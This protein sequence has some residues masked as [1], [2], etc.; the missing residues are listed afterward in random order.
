MDSSDSSDVSSDEVDESSSES[1]SS[2]SSMSTAYVD[3]DGEEGDAYDDD[4]LLT[5]VGPIRGHA[6][7]PA[8]RHL[9]RRATEARMTYLR[10]RRM[11]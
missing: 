10:E 9:I 6:T 7:G 3:A 5:D 4:R 2:V 11:S 8:S 1:S